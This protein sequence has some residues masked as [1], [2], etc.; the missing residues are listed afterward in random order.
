MLLG[1][2]CSALPLSLLTPTPAR[3]DM[4]RWTGLP[5]LSEGRPTLRAAWMSNRR[6][7]GMKLIVPIRKTNNANGEE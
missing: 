6:G 7:Y 3:P 1:L 2:Q 5:A 4:S